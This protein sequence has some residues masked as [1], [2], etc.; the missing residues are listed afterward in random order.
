MNKLIFML[1][2]A[3]IAS[4]AG[5]GEL[6][7][8]KFSPAAPTNLTAV[9]DSGANGTE[10]V[11][12]TWSP[13]KGTTLSQ[14][15]TFNIYRGTA[16]TGALADKTLVV[17]G[18]AATT[19]LDTYPASNV[20]QYYQVTATIYNMESGG[21]NEAIVAQNVPQGPSDN[22]FTLTGSSSSAVNNLS[23][24]ALPGASGYTVYKGMTP[25]RSLSDKIAG[26]FINADAG[27]TA[28][29]DKNVSVGLTYYYQVAAR[30]SDP[31]F[32]TSNE[33]AVT[34]K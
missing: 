20:I 22:L 3:V 31:Q 13:S 24:T 2:I 17:A 33:I 27:T 16:A 1:F 21:S 25:G 7:L 30:Y 5:C 9:G 23:W 32:P 34:T 10:Q 11:L 12:L 26:Q 4:A 14:G 29:T 18:I 8:G 19:Y 6:S 28:L 15:A